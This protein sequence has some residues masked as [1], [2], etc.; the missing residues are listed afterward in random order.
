VKAGERYRFAVEAEALGS[1]LDGVLRLTD[2]S[3]KQLALVDDVD[4][5]PP[6]SGLQGIRS[7]DP[8]LDFT[9][10]P[11]VTALEVELRDGR[12]RG[13]VNFGYRLTVART[14]DFALGQPAAEVNVPRGGAVALTV[15]VTRHGYD[16]PIQVEVPGLPAGLS[17]RGGYVPAGSGQ[18]TLTL[19]AD[20]A[21][22]LPQVPLA[23]GLEGKA[24]APGKDIRRR[25]E[26]ALVVARDANVAVATF[27][28]REFAAALT[29][30]APFA[31]RGPEAVELVNGYPATVKVAVTR[32]PGQKVGA[33]E[34]TGVSPLAP[35]APGRP[36]PKPALTFK[37]GSAAP[38]AGQATFTV[39]AGPDVAEGRAGDVFVQGKA[40][41]NN[42]DRTAAGRAVAVTVVRPF[43]VELLA[44]E[45]S[46]KAGQAAVLKGRIERRPVFREA[47]QLKL[48]GLPKGVTLTAPPRLVPAGQAEF[49]LELRVDPKAAPAAGRL[50]L[51]CTAT[52]N[53]TAYRHPALTV[54][55]RVAP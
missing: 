31:V 49:A 52:I 29:S 7:P 1:A 9:V 16:G 23:L 44:A 41:V 24:L 12:H 39:T 45:V 32:G 34:V 55:V 26:Q 54:A 4:L 22:K 18:G 37:P 14:E 33:V 35:P 17:A 11:G 28:V 36:Q 47:V 25:A 46:L 50:T 38:E 43:R 30:P 40:K 48:D 3:G 13:G 10:P 51:T 2:P 27:P 15:P 19:S 20:P 21:A 5:P 42:A 6:A 8:A 53:G